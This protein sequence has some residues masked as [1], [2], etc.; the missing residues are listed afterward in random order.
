MA[1]SSSTATGGSQ[2][3]VERTRCDCNAGCDEAHTLGEGIVVYFA[4]ERA[5]RRHS[6][7]ARSLSDKT[8]NGTAKPA[9]K[10]ND[11]A[12]RRPRPDSDGELSKEAL[13]KATGGL[14]PAVGQDK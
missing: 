14:L 9:A 5:E 10:Q 8:K 6:T 3:K 1:W 2:R 4:T 7:G 12:G 11:K 13:D